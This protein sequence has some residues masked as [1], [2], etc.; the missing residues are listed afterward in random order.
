LR[1]WWVEKFPGKL[2][3]KPEFL[4]GSKGLMMSDMT[5]PKDRQFDEPFFFFDFDDNF[6][7]LV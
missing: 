2:L 1:W 3:E 4:L 5:P 6:L 7:F